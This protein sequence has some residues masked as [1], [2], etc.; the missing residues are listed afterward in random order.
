MLHGEMFGVIMGQLGQH[1]IE[2]S[3]ATLHFVSTHQMQQT[4]PN[5]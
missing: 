3:G 5:D 4:H 2:F 1:I